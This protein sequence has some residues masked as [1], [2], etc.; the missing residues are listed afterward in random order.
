VIIDNKRGFGHKDA[1]EFAVVDAKRAGA[2]VKS[3]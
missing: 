3:G 1:L 2:D